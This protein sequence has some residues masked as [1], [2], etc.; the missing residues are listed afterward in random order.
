MSGTG[1][2]CGGEV[3]QGRFVTVI[4]VPRGDHLLADFLKFQRAEAKIIE[5]EKLKKV[6]R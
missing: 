1:W 4:G 3:N 6:L 2:N 5:I